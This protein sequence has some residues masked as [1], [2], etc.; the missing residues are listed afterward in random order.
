M[1][2]GDS[3]VILRLSSAAR[4]SPTA[5]MAALSNGKIVN[6]AGNISSVQKKTGYQ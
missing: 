2:L 1:L 6:S 4:R 3:M 5:Q